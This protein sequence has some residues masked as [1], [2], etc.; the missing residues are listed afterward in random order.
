MPK[1]AHHVKIVKKRRAQFIRF[2]S[3]PSTHSG[4]VKPSW[5]K[6]HGIDSRIRRKFRGNR[7]MPE[8]GYGSDKRTKFLRP[9]GFKAFHVKNVGDLSLLLMHNT[10]YA[11]I[12]AHNVSAKNRKKIVERADQ[13]DIKVVN[14]NAKLRSQE[15]E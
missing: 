2:Q 4:R 11:A 1:A 3:D 10:K 5:R 6:P 14:R 15:S 7:P 9:D 13:L 12:I 8:V